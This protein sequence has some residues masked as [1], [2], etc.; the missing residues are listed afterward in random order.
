MQRIASIAA[1]VILLALNAGC[2]STARQA[3]SGH[4]AQPIHSAFEDDFT[5][6]GQ[7]PSALPSATLSMPLSTTRQSMPTTRLP[8]SIAENPP[9]INSGSP[10]PGQA[11]FDLNVEGAPIREVLMSLVKGTP[12]NMIVHPSVQGEISLSLKAVAIDDVLQVLRNVYGYEYRRTDIGYE[13]LAQGMQ[14]RLFKIDYLNVKRSGE[15]QVRVSSGQ[16]SENR[17]NQANNTTAV[18]QQSQKSPQAGSAL[19]GSEVNTR[20]ES[21]FWADL[22]T[23]LRAMIGEADGRKVVVNPQTGIIMVKAMPVE[24]RDVEDYLNT[25]QGT[26]QRQVILEA[27]VVEVELSDGFQSGI[28]WAAF[29]HNGTSTAN[30][31]QVGGGS[32]FNGEGVSETAGTAID[33][34]SLSGVEGLATSAF[35]GVFSLA[36]ATHDFTAFIEALASQGEVHVLS[37][38]RLSTVNN[39]KAVIKVGTDEFFVT[40]IQT[41]TTE[42]SSSLNRAVD[43]ELTPFFSGVALDVIPQINDSGEV[44]LYIH[45]SVSEV[46]EKTKEIQVSTGA[47]GALK[48]PLALSTI[49]ESDSIIRA[50]SGQLVVI[51]GLMQNISHDNEAGIPYISDLPLVGALFRHRKQVNVKSELVILLRPIIVDDHN[52]VWGAYVDHTRSRFDR[53]SGFESPSSNSAPE[54]SSQTARQFP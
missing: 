1:I 50:Q 16:L 6:G 34:S 49:R 35:G 17:P 41:Q 39:Q 19:S 5:T 37:S 30:I 52:G 23:T 42:I 22:Q 43:V 29:L 13:V 46:K 44:T 4:G 28:N 10:E 38:P 25:I 8:S 12:Y 11:R 27:K 9:K 15:S 45:P 48:V 21:D 24:L 3:Q 7:K 54:Q 26:I 36:L 18:N 47:D 32:V 40:G 14:S 2:A 51:G 53:L 33:L 31:G 20:S